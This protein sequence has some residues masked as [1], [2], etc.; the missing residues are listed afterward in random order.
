M[1]KKMFKKIQSPGHP[2]WSSGRR[3]RIDQVAYQG[4]KLSPEYR[5]K[6]DIYIHLFYISNKVW[7][8]LGEFET[9]VIPNEYI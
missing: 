7:G 6:E 3:L 9:Q 5:T 1:L 8:G 4:K 2:G